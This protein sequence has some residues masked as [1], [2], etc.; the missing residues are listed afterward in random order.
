LLESELFGYEGGAFTGARK[1]GKP[2]LFELAHRGT[3]FLDEIGEIALGVQARL[4]RVLEE[5]E[6]MR[7]GGDRVIPVD[8]RIIAATNKNLHELAQESF[9]KDLFYRLCV[10]LLRL[11]PLRERPEDVPIFL[12]YFLRELDCILPR[13]VLTAI[14]EHQQFRTYQWPGNVRQLRNFAE[15]LATL[16]FMTQDPNELVSLALTTYTSTAEEESRKDEVLRALKAA[17]GNRKEAAELLG[18]SRTT[19]W[20]RMREWGLDYD[21]TMKQNETAN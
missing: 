7:I 9:R 8:V 16:A 5:R 4:L 17:G 20:R 2:G 19:L 15:R 3:I 11:P 21:E 12:E 13:P 1:Q 18:I 14:M 10:L 6:V